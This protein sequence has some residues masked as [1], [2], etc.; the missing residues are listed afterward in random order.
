M[1]Q[2]HEVTIKSFMIETL[3]GLIRAWEGCCCCPY[4]Y[5]LGSKW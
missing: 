1:Y 3:P 2:D 4:P 5:T